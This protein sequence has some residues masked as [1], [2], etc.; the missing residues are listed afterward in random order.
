MRHLR[1]TTERAASLLMGLAILAACA[2]AALYAAGFRPVAVYSGSME[3]SLPVGS[4]AFVETVRADDLRPGD[5]V[6]FTHP[7][8]PGELVTHRIV[9][10]ADG[11]Q[12]RVY[13]TKGDAN[14]APDPW[15][16]RLRDKA[17]RLAFEIPRAGYAL[18]YLRTREARTSLVALMAAL[19]LAGLLRAIWRPGAPSAERA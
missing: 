10:I 3:P 18:A 7:Y 14:A 6:T 1:T 9:A 11:A 2:Y 16:I 8:R 19:A 17:G 4:L 12:G 13:R 15:A 5:V